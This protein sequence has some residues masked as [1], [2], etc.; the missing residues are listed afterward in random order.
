VN[1]RLLEDTI[2]YLED[3]NVGIAVNLDEGVMVPM[4]PARTGWPS[5]TSPAGP[6]SSRRARAKAN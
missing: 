5:S 2:V 3:V 1:C 4:V 6:G